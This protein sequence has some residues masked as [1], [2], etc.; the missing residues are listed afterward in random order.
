[1]TP[2][3]DE[4][5]MQRAL[6]L[7]AGGQGHVEPNPPVGCVLVAADGTFLAEGFHA[8]YGGDHAEVAALKAARAAGREVRGA[9]A[10]V[11]LEPCAHQGKTPPCCDALIEAGVSRVVVAARDPFAQVNG[12]GLSRLREAGMEVAA[13][14]HEA[15]AIWQQQAFRLRVQAQRPQVIL[16][17]AQ[18]LDGR[19]AT[20]SGDSRWIS[21]EASRARVHQLRATCD[22]IV[23][24]IGTALADDPLLTVRGVAA[25]GRQPLRV[26]VDPQLKLSASARLLREGDTPVLLACRADAADS[27]QAAALRAAGA[28]VQP[29]PLRDDGALDLQA[30]VVALLDAADAARGM[31]SRVLVE[32]GARLH[33]HFLRQ[34]LVDQIQAFVAPKLLGDGQGI[35]VMDGLSVT[36]MASAHALSLRAVERIGDDMLLIYG[37]RQGR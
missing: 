17:W 20:R 1:M 16:K 28:Q 30:L 2:A 29:L 22:A 33:G 13:G 7:A 21:S 12:R 14:V 15:E 32:G 3:A 11:T 10:Y 5:W 8:A 37:N 31:A 4:R 25:P 35:P 24:G 18:T 19:M 34:G 6:A 26:V 27:P 9:T 23:V 36:D